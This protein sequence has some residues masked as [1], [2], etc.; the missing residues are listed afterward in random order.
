MCLVV[1][2][3]IFTFISWVKLVAR[4]CGL[5]AAFLVAITFPIVRKDVPPYSPDI[6]TPL[7]PPY[8]SQRLLRTTRRG[9]NSSP[10]RCHGVTP[11]AETDIL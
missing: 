11:D 10:P 4:Q 8:P 3:Y 9:V 2:H 6:L 7:P 5:Y 1:V